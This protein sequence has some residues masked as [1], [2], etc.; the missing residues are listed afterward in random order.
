MTFFRLRVSLSINQNNQGLARMDFMAET[1]PLY[2]FMQDSDQD[3]SLTRIFL[4]RLERARSG[5]ARERFAFALGVFAAIHS[6]PLSSHDEERRKLILACRIECFRIFHELATTGLAEAAQMVA[7]CY[8]Y[9][10]GVRRDLAA[11]K[12]WIRKARGMPGA[13]QN[14]LN[15]LR[16]SIQLKTQK[17]A[18]TSVP[19]T[20]LAA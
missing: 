4:T 6:K 13:N 20:A 10:K 18:N 2:R 5:G 1:Y 17:I 14:V 11:A 8:T 7:V 15:G 16:L 19:A 12:D 9:S 3:G